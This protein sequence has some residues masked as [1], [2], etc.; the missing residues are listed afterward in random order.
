[1]A[2]I[3]GWLLPGAAWDVGMKI[4]VSR[5]RRSSSLG[6][7]V[8]IR[9]DADRVDLLLRA[10]LDAVT[11]YARAAGGDPSRW[12]SMTLRCACC[13]SGPDGHRRWAMPRRGRTSGSGSLVMTTRSG[14][15]VVVM[16]TA[17]D[18]GDHISLDVVHEPVLLGYA[19]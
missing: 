10:A 14:S 8:R 6:G 11:A 12:R 18:N 19:A 16:E 5:S 7:G 15:V 2:Q 17:G 3:P 9:A 13:R 4:F 1:M